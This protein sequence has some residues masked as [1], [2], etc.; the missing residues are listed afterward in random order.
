MDLEKVKKNYEWDP[1]KG[2]YTKLDVYEER[3]LLKKKEIRNKVITV[4]YV[5]ILIISIIVTVLSF[6]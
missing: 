4:L 5:L 1:H 2:D 3:K 6:N